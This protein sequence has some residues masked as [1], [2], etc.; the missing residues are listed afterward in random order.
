MNILKYLKYLIYIEKIDE[1]VQ[2]VKGAKTGA[3]E[4]VEQDMSIDGVAGTL[5]ISWVPK[6]A[7]GQTEF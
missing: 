6:T 5:A 3:A 2:A 1:L 4:H 7:A